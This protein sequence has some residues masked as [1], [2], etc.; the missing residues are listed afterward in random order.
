MASGVTGKDGVSYK[1]AVSHLITTCATLAA[2]L[3]FV[4]LGAKVVP[5]ALGSAVRDPATNA[6]LVAFLL[7]IAIV[8]VGYRRAAT[9]PRRWPR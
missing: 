6:L 8:L 7:N 4:I 9:W 2:I 3:L 5:S 1:V